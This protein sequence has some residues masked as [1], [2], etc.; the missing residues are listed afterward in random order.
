M[1]D[2]IMKGSE[3]SRHNAHPLLTLRCALCSAHFLA[4]PCA[5]ACCGSKAFSLIQLAQQ[6]PDLLFGLCLCNT[7]GILY[8][9][10]WSR[11]WCNGDR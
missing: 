7:L 11:S 9:C 5:R 1:L 4:G 3:P 6:V 8:T 10:L 2:R